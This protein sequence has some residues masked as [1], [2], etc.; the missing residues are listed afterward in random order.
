MRIAIALGGTDLGKSGIGTYV[1]AVLPRLS[2][3]LR[4]DAGAIVAIGTREDLAAYEG[5]L[6]ASE[7]IVLS[8]AFGKPGPS[9]AWH[10]LRAGDVALR[11]RADVLLLPAANRRL[12]ARSPIPTVQ[13]VHD[14]AQLHVAA[15]YDVLRMFYVRRVV[16]A[17]L[18]SATVL[19]SVS[20]ATAR[21]LR[22]VLGAHPPPIRVVPNGVE[23]ERFSPPS[24]PDDPRIARAREHTCVA[25]PYVLYAARLEH[26]GKNHLRLLRAFAASR[27]RDT[28]TLALAGGDWGAR[29][30]IVELARKLRLGERVKLVGFVPDDV[31]PGLVAGADAVAM[32]GLHEGFGLPALEALASGRPVLASRTGALPEVVG[33]LAALCDPH[34][35]ASVRDAL[36]RAL[37]DDALRAHARDEGP[38]WAR[39]HDWQLTADGVLD[40]CREAARTR[41]PPSVRPK[42]RSRTDMD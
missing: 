22:R 29:K 4:E 34:D 42:A 16:I 32:L 38:A 30:Q 24:G 19:V 1:K 36:E 12:T 27:A 9:A 35:D 3:R 13:V 8:G 2:A 39:A 15:K 11:A 33:S 26:P 31:L 40:A 18:R 7:R 23:H 6:G 14:L 5:P 25:G 41:P 21:D 20:E 10:L 17:A 28:H 37:F